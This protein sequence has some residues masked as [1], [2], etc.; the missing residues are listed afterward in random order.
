VKAKAVAFLAGL[1]FGAGLLVSGMTQPAKVVG[2][3]DFGGA[4][5]ASLAFVMVGGIG[6]LI[7]ANLLARAIGRPIFADRFPVLRRNEIDG[8][9]VGGAAVFG[10]GWGLSGFCPGPAVVSLGGGTQGAL[11]FVSAML[12]GMALAR[13]FSPARL[14]GRDESWGLNQGPAGSMGE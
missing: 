1:L 14:V 2:F 3:L 9:V 5:D 11:I 10:I 8:R 7:V 6:V 4:W 12:V 13:V